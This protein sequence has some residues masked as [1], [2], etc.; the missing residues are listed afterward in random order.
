MR[1]IF[2]AFLFLAGIIEPVLAQKFNKKKLDSLMNELSVHNKAMGTLVISKNSNPVYQKSIGYSFIEGSQKASLDTNTRYRVGSITKMFTAAII[3]QLVEEGRLTLAT[4]LS[5]FFAQLPNADKITIGHMLNHSSGLFDY[6]K[7]WDSWRF[8]TKT[9]EE[10]VN[11]IAAKKPEF[12][13][14]AKT[15]YSSSNYIIL[16]YIIEKLCNKSYA[17]VLK[18]RITSKIGISNTY[19]GGKIDAKNNEAFSYAFENATWTKSPETNMTAAGG[20]GA[21]VSTAKDL[22]TFIHALFSHKLVSRESLNHMLTIKDGVGM[23]VEKLPFYDMPVYG[24]SGQIDLFQSWLLYFPN[25]SVSVV[26]LSNGYGGFPVNEVL[27]GILHIY[28]NKPYTLPNFKTVSLSAEE[29]NSYTGV[30]DCKQPKMR[31]TITRKVAGLF[32]QATGQS[33]FLLEPVEQDRF[34]S[35]AAGIV[36]EFLPGKKEFILKQGSGSYS[37]TRSE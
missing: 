21:I 35:D 36:I 18:E 27:K 28:Y 22:A 14:G 30:Y 9:P 31:V 24:H 11:I 10:I 23:G 25:D 19:Y 20:A 32:A 12:E 6:L 7:E 17:Q 37:F 5:R 2:I 4:P 13:P 33:A 3:F 16:G 8:G 1:K 34:K 26:Y 29:L 15:V